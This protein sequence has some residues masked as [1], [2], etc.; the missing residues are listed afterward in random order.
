[1]TNMGATTNRDARLLFDDESLAA[2]FTA[3]FEHDWQHIAGP[4]TSRH[5][6]NAEL[7]VAGDVAP[8]EGFRPFEWK[9]WLEGA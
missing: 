7:R 9:A 4:L 5:W 6:R 1:M 8:D 2:Y 3:L